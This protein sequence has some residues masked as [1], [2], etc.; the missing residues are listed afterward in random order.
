MSI[1][2]TLQAALKAS[3]LLAANTNVG[4]TVFNARFV[5]PLDEGNILDL[6]AS[7]DLVVTTEDNVVDGGFGSAI[8]ELMANHNM[9]QQTQV[10]R[11]G[12]N[13]MFVPH[14]SIPE[15]HE[16]CAMDGTAIF[17]KIIQTLKASRSTALSLA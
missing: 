9:L 17:N 5:K 2:W 16:L 7:H 13:D 8:L 4:S 10:L 1:G 14:G 3:E 6:V 12:I 11:I 15:L